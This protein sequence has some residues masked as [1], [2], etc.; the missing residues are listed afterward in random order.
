VASELGA[1]AATQAAIYVANFGTDSITRI[2][3]MCTPRTTAIDLGQ[4]KARSWIDDVASGRVRSFAE[5]AE[6]GQGGETHPPS[7]AT[8]VHPATYL[9]R[10]H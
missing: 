2:D 5:I 1:S 10:D 3:F 6:R 7:H 4:A 9:G 8:C